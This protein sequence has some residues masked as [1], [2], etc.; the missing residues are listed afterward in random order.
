MLGKE[1]GIC[2]GHDEL[3]SLF[4]A[5]RERKPPIRQYYRTGLFSDGRKIIWEY[6]RVSPKG[7]QMDFVEVMEINDQGLIQHH[8]VYWGW[9]GVPVLQRDEYHKKE[10]PRDGTTYR[11]DGATKNR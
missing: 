2:R 9:F 8:G 1:I 11:K 10:E 5:L 7:E 4:E 6:P 3:R